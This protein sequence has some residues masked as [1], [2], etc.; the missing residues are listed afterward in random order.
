MVLGYLL[1]PVSQ[2]DGESGVLL[3]TDALQPEEEVKIIYNA[4]SY[5]FGSLKKLTSVSVSLK[6]FL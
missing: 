3:Q 1:I 2:S 4:N 6:L 5:F